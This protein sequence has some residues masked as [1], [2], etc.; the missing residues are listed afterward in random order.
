MLCWVGVS[1]CVKAAIGEGQVH[2]GA[3]SSVCLLEVSPEYYSF[4]RRNPGTRQALFRK[5]KTCCCFS[6]AYE[7]HW[8]DKIRLFTREH[9]IDR[10]QYK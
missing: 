5:A 3:A 6:N 10:G 2:A 7:K 1:C 8:Y 4:L 9:V